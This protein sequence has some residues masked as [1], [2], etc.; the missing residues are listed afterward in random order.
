VGDNHNDVPMLK[1]ADRAFL[2]EPKTPTMQAESGAE[3]F[4]SF[5]ELLNHAPE[6]P[7]APAAAPAEDTEP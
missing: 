7:A 5:E 2:I 1:A 3:V 6:P 4:T